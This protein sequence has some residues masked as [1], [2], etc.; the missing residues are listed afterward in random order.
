[1]KKSPKSAALKTNRRRRLRNPALQTLDKRLVL[2]GAPPVAVNDVFA[3]TQDVP[4]NITAPGL[5]V[6][7][8]D[9]ES[10]VLSA[11]LFSGPAHGTLSLQT[12]GSF[13]YTPNSGFTGVDSFTYRANDGTSFSTLAAV[14]LKVGLGSH[15]PVLDLDANDSA[16]TG[17]NFATTFT[18]DGGP[19]ALADV[20]ATLTDSDSPNLASLTVTI[21]NLQDGAL[22]SL[23]AN[24]AGTSISASYDSGTGALMLSGGDTVAHYLQVLKTVSYANASQHPNTMNR[25]ITLVANDGSHDSNAAV[26]TLT[27]IGVN[28]PPTAASDSYTVNED[29]TL[30]VPA[31]GV[32]ANDSDPDGDALTAVLASGPAHGA[33]TLN[34]DGSFSYTPDANFNGTDSFSY[35]ANDGTVDSN[36]TTVTINVNPVNDPPQTQNDV[37]ST[38]EDTPLIVAPGAGVLANDTDVEGD[39]LTAVLVSGPMHGVV[40]LNPDGSF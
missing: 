40:T 16:A 27:V 18:E 13:G 28:D 26:T 33:L 12:D 1:M 6:N 2:S 29:N 30:N 10:D 20:D 21:A 22:E 23:S 31:S 3:V 38:N 14:T 5:L 35:K 19:V 7:D 37:Y 24:T 9:A 32:L 11:S 4:L 8:T 15:P 36:L 34:S 17:A 25:T 39:T